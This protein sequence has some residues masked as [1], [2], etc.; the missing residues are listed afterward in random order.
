MI[1]WCHDVDAV[2][3]AAGALKSY[4]TLLATQC[5]NGSLIGSRK[6]RFIKQ[7]RSTASMVMLMCINFLSSACDV[8]CT[9]VLR[10]NIVDMEYA[11]E[12]GIQRRK[13][14]TSGVIQH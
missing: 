11:P 14:T 10:S 13:N 8:L 6:C 1:F 2:G 12:Q 4:C 3:L 9:R 5:P 7:I